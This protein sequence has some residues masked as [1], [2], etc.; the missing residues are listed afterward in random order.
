[1]IT[2]G[3]VLYPQPITSEGKYKTVWGI[4]IVFKNIDVQLYCVWT[5][6]ANNVL[7]S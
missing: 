3:Q 7:N 2:I 4:G 1:M 6:Y 5:K